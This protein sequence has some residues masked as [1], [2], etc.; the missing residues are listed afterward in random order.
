MNGIL[1]QEG[2]AKLPEASQPLSFKESIKTLFTYLF[3]LLWFYKV[4]CL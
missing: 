3:F 1:T 4:C 2:K